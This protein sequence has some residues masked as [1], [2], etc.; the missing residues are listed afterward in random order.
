[1]SRPHLRPSSRW[2]L[3]D[4]AHL[5]HDKNVREP[6]VLDMHA[7]E[8]SIAL[9]LHFKTSGAIVVSPGR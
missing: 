2:P 7:G 5:W 8:W 1:M 6:I 4:F 3:R 9:E